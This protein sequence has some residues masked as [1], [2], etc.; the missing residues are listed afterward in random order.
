MIASTLPR[1]RVETLLV[2]ALLL[3]MAFGLLGSRPLWDPDEGRYTNVALTMLDRDDWL[4]P[5]RSEEAEHWTKPPLTYWAIAAS[6]SVFGP[7]AWAARLPM[8]LAFLAAAL[9]VGVMARQLAPG[10]ATW[11][12]LAF[13][14]MFL[15]VVAAQIATTDMLLCAFCALAMTGYVAARFGERSRSGILVMWAGLGL[16]FLTKGPPGLFPL[17]AVLALH[18]LSPRERRPRLLI[19]P[20]LALF[21]LIGLG[22]YAYVV[23]RDPSLLHYFI[24]EEVVQRIA[25]HGFG[26]NTGPWGWAAVYVPALLLGTLPWTLRLARWLRS[27]GDGAAWSAPRSWAADRDRAPDLLIALWIGLPLIVLCLASSR[28]PLYVLPLMAPIA[29]AVAR[30]SPPAPL[31]LSRGHA[32]LLAAW[33]L[34]L[35]GLRAYGAAHDTSADAS[36]WAHAL[37]ERVSEPIREVVFVDDK[38]RYGL[39]LYLDAEVEQLGNGDDDAAAIAAG[40][41]HALGRELAEDEP[42]IVFVTT[43]RHWPSVRDCVARHHRVASVQGTTYQGRVVFT[44]HDQP[45]TSGAAGTTGF[46]PPGPAHPRRAAPP[47]S[48]GTV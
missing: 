46:A 29:L 45:P 13:G 28:L 47:A 41:D 35:L 8:A 32:S 25:G 43:E 38:P 21:A 4:I 3:V 6:V 16:A 19:V 44:V 39:H 23:A 20:G 48:T 27:L 31:V 37:R 7:T 11:A 18:V 9:L 34:A 42:G 14:T 10:R 40:R 15:P 26:R 30:M 1:P 33:A 5:M 17:L 36:S 12:V 24:G 22:W 2:A